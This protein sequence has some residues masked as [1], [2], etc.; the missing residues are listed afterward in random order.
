MQMLGKLVEVQ[1]NAKNSSL[2]NLNFASGI[3]VTK[4]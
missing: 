4:P 3:Q 2:E 1:H